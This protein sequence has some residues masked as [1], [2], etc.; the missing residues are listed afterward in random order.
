M[1]PALRILGCV[2]DRKLLFILGFLLLAILALPGGLKDASAFTWDEERAY[3]AGG[4][5]VGTV[6]DSEGNNL[7]YVWVQQGSPNNSIFFKWFD[8]KK[9]SLPD[10]LGYAQVY[11]GERPVM[12]VEDGV[13]HVVWRGAE[14]GDTGIYYR[15]FNGSAWSDPVLLTADLFP[16]DQRSPV[17]A[18]DGPN[19]HVA[20][21]DQRDGDYDVVY[22]LFDGK[23]WLL[24][25]EIS[26]DVTNEDQA[27]PDMVVD[28]G[29]VHLIWTMDHQVHH[30]VKDAGGWGEITDVVV[31]ESKHW[32]FYPSLA[33]SDG[34]V[35]IAFSARD[36]ASEM[37]INMTVNDGGEWNTWGRV[38]SI[39]HH[40]DP[41]FRLDAEKGNLVLVYMEMMATDVTFQHFNGSG[42]SEAEFINDSSAGDQWLPQ[43][44]LVDGVVHVTYS[45]MGIGKHKR[46]FIEE[47]P[48]LSDVK[49]L[50]S[51]W[52]DP[53]V[54]DLQWTLS[55]DFGID[56]ISLEYRHSTDNATWSE[57]SEIMFEDGESGPEASGTFSFEPADGD[58][59]YELRTI[60]TD[61][62]GNVEPA[63]AEAEARA[64]LDTTA[65]EGSIDI[66]DGMGYTADTTVTLTLSFDD[67]TSGVSKVRI[68]NEAI[69]GD[70]P[71][72]DP[73]E[74][75]QWDLGD[76]GG[77]VTVYYQ[78]ID[79][80]GHVS[81]VHS[82]DIVL[83][84]ELPT[85]TIV[86]VPGELVIVNTTLITLTLTFEDDTEVEAIRLSNDGIWAE[87]DWRAPTGSVAWQLPEGDIGRVVYYQ[88]KD[89][90]EKVSEIYELS[91]RVDTTSP[92]L[93]AMDPADGS[94]EVPVNASIRFQF[95]EVLKPLS[96]KANLDIS[97]L[98]E[99]E[100]SHDLIGNI[101]WEQNWQ[102]F[103]FEPFSDLREGTTYYVNMG[104]DVQDLAGNGLYPAVMYSF[105]TEGEPPDG[106]SDNG[107]DTPWGVIILLVLIIA[108]MGAVIVF[109]LFKKEGSAF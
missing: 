39:R 68:S 60:G 79:M 2:T 101:T 71:W 58:G 106:G 100:V 46:G 12:A 14:R 4:T 69:D 5:V 63:P 19:V 50:G 35:Y 49:R 87:F 20:W 84:T 76:Q 81:Q 83:D 17:I 59:F 105:T 51:Y 65:P 47:G 34:V 97:F 23:D 25:E 27:A 109:L 77:Q 93:E 94:D 32:P 90:T 18:V 80:A 54:T 29:R 95:S 1:V 73:A 107:T 10:W 26:I 7:Y 74:T 85:G 38:N 40:Y 78:V 21:L 82:D 22:R 13:V 44:R 28:E 61:I 36:E 55:D 57:W 88:V 102:T 15:S 98:D 24:S 37:C 62:W 52:M 9:W 30:R 8:G 53:A 66:E 42:W 89:A 6:A 92:R 99:D 96:V 108:L 43:V 64:G 45:D 70:E 48:P 11:S 91:L 3:T 104:P 75:R 67:A 103:T 86:V 72:E 56:S 16:I 31:M 33:A 41:Y